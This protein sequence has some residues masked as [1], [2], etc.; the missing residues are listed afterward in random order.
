MAKDAVAR[1]VDELVR[2]RP[3]STAADEARQTAEH[4]LLKVIT[5]AGVAALDATI[6]RLNAA[7]HRLEPIERT[8]TRRH[9]RETI[10]DRGT[11]LD[12]VV[13][14]NPELRMASVRFVG[15]PPVLDARARRRQL[16]QEAFYARYMAAGRRAY[17]RPP[18]RIGPVDRLV[19]LVGELEADVNNGGFDQ[20]LSNKGRRRA[21]GALEALRTIGARRTA[22]LLESALRPSVSREQLLALDDRF[23]AA[24]EDLAVLAMRHVESRREFIA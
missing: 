18:R 16:V 19:L 8:E 7:G 17:A 9:W 11:A 5:R 12:I 10:D 13:S 20:Y 6:A 22:R 3:R 24:P 1:L 21:R 15:P 23:H 14:A 2:L 4:L